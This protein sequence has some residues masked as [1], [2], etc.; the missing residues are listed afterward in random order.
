V[1]NLLYLIAI[2]PWVLTVGTLL[3][4]MVR[5]TEDYENHDYEEDGDFIQDEIESG[6]ARIKVAVYEDK[7]YWVYQNVLYESETTKEPAFETARPV[8]VMALPKKDVNKLLGILD[9]L[10][11]DN[12]RD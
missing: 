8:D 7:A 6:Q 5:D 11:E 12:E 10:E 9:D 4:I 3:F 1:I 2:I